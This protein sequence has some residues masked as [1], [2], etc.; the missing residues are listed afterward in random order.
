M[1]CYRDMTFCVSPACANKCGRKL[2]DEV[3]AAAKRWWKGDGAPISMAEYCDENGEVI[4][5]DPQPSERGANQGKET[6]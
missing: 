1:I 6:Q 5:A 2:T 4:R 3:R